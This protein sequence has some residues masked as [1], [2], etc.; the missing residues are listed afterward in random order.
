MDSFKTTAGNLAGLTIA[1]GAAASTPY[2]A[3]ISTPSTAADHSRSAGRPPPSAAT[4]AV[5]RSPESSPARAVPLPRAAPVSRSSA[6]RIPIP[7]APALRAA[8]WPSTAPWP[9][10]HGCHRHGRRVGRLG[11]DQWQRHAHRQWRRQS[12]GRHDRRHPGRDRRQLARHR[13]RG[14]RRFLHQRVF[15]LGSGAESDCPRRPELQRRH[16]GRP[17]CADRQRHALRRPRPSTSPAARSPAPSPRP[18]A[19]GSARAASAAEYT[20]TAA[21]SS[22]TAR[23]TAAAP[24]PSPPAPRWPATARSPARTP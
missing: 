23:K 17:R 20:S 9:R 2:S 7:A 12:L 10:K 11:H 16:P 18:A 21:P 19:I 24:T 4:A 1:S 8:P 6:A 5:A 14:R 15:T 3:S 22:S 13:P